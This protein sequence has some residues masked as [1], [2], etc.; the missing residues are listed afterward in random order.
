M[1]KLKTISF[2]LA[3]CLMLL[4]LSCNNKEYLKVPSSDLIVTKTVD[5]QTPLMGQNVTFT[6][7]LT[8]AGPSTAT[9]IIVADA[10]PTGY[11][12]ISSTVTAGTYSLLQDEEYGA[13]GAIIIEIK[14]EP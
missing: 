13:F 12:Y 10:L 9:S 14:C 7:L 3:L 4:L 1:I 8:N 2:H 6:I 5:N 11:T